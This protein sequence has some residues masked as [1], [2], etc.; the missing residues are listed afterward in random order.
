MGVKFRKHK[1][2]KA[3]A[4]QDPDVVEVEAEEFEGKMPEDTINI[5]GEQSQDQT[6]PEMTEE[7]FLNA[8]YREYQA[9]APNDASQMDEQTFK[10]AFKAW[11]QK[12]A[13][14]AGFDQSQQDYNGA[15]EE[16]T[17][18]GD[19]D[20]DESLNGTEF[21]F[22]QPDM[23]N[24]GFKGYY[25]QK[26]REIQSKGTCIKGFATTYGEDKFE[27]AFGVGTG[28]LTQNG[29][30]YERSPREPVS[31]EEVAA[32]VDFVK[33]MGWDNIDLKSNRHGKK[34]KKALTQ[35]LYENGITVNGQPGLPLPGQEQQNQNTQTADNDQQNQQNHQN[36]GQ[37]QSRTSRFDNNTNQN[38]ADTSGQVVPMP[39]AQAP[40]ANQQNKPAQLKKSTIGV[41]PAA[42]PTP[43]N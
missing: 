33:E 16:P 18:E 3:N 30:N 11:E 27:I 23:Q 24:M 2:D 1:N 37:D 26:L 5:G 12:K 13:Q 40:T 32:M 6:G 10:T 8:R 9:K 34:F 14:D 19:P 22:E 29:L 20:S 17:N 43:K 4:P 35:A 39:D 38:T 41:L 31:E 7:E 25:S 28:T 42:N 36:S 15:D 21:S